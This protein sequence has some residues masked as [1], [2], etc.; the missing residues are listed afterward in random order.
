MIR[1][2]EPNFRVVLYEG[3]GAD[4]LDPGE[5]Y[6]F[7]SALLEEGL[8][9]TRPS[10]EGVVAADDAQGANN[11]TAETF[12]I[13]VSPPDDGGAVDLPTDFNG[14]GKVDLFD[15][16]LFSDAF[17][18]PVVEDNARFDLDDSGAV[19]LFDFFLFAETF[20]DE[21]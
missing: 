8:R 15:F 5:R 16:F 11:V 7:V 20:G 21:G 2:S 12:A 18:Q 14:S 13:T 17:G 4:T 9:V 19:N 1:K 3:S 10:P 6:D